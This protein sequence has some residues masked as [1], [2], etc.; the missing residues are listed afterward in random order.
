ML[1]DLGLH[2][3]LQLYLLLFKTAFLIFNILDVYQ[4]KR[5]EMEC[6]LISLRMN[7]ES[8]GEEC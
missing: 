5:D 8:L 6:I 4:T 7:M 3:I 1:Q 2:T